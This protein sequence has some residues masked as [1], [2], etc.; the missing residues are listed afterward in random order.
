L[1]S[2]ER[3]SIQAAPEEQEKEKDD[4]TASHEPKMA[5]PVAA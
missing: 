2:P 3:Q 1:Q 4:A 5:E